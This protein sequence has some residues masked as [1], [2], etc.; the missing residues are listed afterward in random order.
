MARFLASVMKTSLPYPLVLALI[1]ASVFLADLLLA[2]G[3]WAVL[4]VLALLPWPGNQSRRTLRVVALA[5]SAL[6][7]AAP[8]LAAASGA[9]RPVTLSLLNVLL[10]LVIIWAAAWLVEKRLAAEQ[11]LAGSRAELAALHEQRSAQLREAKAV[12]QSEIDERARAQQQ[13]GRS[14]AHCLSL[15]ENLPIH[16]IRKDPEGR[17]TFASQSFCELLGVPCAPGTR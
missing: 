6:A 9:D 10:S 12:L 4:Y 13:L 5:F 11:N 7:I 1:A 2:N 16:V 8:L 15:I 17:F 3:P 14:E